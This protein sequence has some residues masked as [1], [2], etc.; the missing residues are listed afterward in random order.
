M[1]LAGGM[2]MNYYSGTRYTED[3]GAVFSRKI[4]LPYEDLPANY[5]KEDDSEGFIYLTAIIP[6]FKNGVGKTVAKL[7]NRQL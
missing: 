4:L 3:V 1:I 6:S 5:T 2:A 7:F